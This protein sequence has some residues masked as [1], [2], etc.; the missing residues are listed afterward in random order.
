M[1]HCYRVVTIGPAVNKPFSLFTPYLHTVACR[2][3]GCQAALE[4]KYFGRIRSFSYHSE[5]RTGAGFFSW[6]SS[7]EDK[8]LAFR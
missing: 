1:A 7:V 2:V 4:G 3:P 6:S 5:P 8:R